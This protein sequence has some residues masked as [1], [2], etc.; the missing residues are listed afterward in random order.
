L[1]ANLLA[2]PLTAALLLPASLLAAAAALLQPAAPLTESLLSATA[3]LAGAALSGAERIASWLPASPPCPPPS[4]SALLLGFALAV[5][6]TRVPATS[7]KIAVA[8]AGAALLAHSPTPEIAPLPPRVVVLDVGQGAA[9]IVQGRGAAILFDGGPALPGG[10]DLGRA[11]VVPALA[12]LGVARLELVIASH[13]DLDHR[14]GLDSVLES[15][16]TTRLWLPAGGARDPVFSSLVAA[17]KERGTLVAEKGEGD[18]AESFADLRVTPL[19]PPRSRELSHNEASLVVRVEV[20]GTRVLLTGDIEAGAEAA[21]LSSGADCAPRCSSWPITAA[22]P[23]RRCVLRAVS[24][25]VRS[26]RRPVRAVRCPSRRSR[27]AGALGRRLVDGRTAVLS[28]SPR[29]A[30]SGWAPPLRRVPAARFAASSLARKEAGM[31]GRPWR[32]PTPEARP[33]GSA[34]RREAIPA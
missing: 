17:A 4:T 19:W 20:A 27:S 6:V 21:L 32:R 16:P 13:G 9:V 31:I 8:A 7:A 29:P 15:V 30:V 25:A 23:R 22:A 1:L 12:A 33:R 34:S 14:G 18:R 26:R 2:I 5:L 24:P 10:L 3:M 28:A 11:A